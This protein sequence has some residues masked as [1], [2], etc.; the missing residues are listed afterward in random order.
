MI[1][2]EDQLEIIIDL[3]NSASERDCLD[4]AGY[5]LRGQLI[6]AMFKKKVISTENL[7]DSSNQT[8]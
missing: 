4:E 5:L 6:T 2:T 3:F 1:L 8:A 7:L